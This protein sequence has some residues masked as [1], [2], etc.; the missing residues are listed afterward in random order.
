MARRPFATQLVVFDADGE[1]DRRP[2]EAARPPEK[3]QSRQQQARS[4]LPPL[5]HRGAVGDSCATS[6]LRAPLLL[7]PRR[8]LGGGLPVTV[9]TEETSDGLAQVTTVLIR[10]PSAGDGDSKFRITF[11][12]VLA[13]KALAGSVKKDDDEDRGE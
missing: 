9:A 4:L 1:G 6:E 13:D 5:R 12:C 3:Q 7:P 8:Q 11:G 2:A 10:L